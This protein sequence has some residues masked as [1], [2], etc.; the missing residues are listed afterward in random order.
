[1]ECYFISP[2]NTN[3]S[4]TF[5]IFAWPLNPP[6]QL[7]SM[8]NATD[9]RLGQEPGRDLSRRRELRDILTLPIR[10]E[11]ARLVPRPR[12]PCQRNL[13]KPS[14]YNIV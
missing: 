1:M 10:L 9:Y 11:L 5:P 8:T 6:G 2:A 12:Y 7:F 3:T 4:F 13:P 14:S